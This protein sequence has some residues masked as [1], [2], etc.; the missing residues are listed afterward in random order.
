[1]ISVLPQPAPYD[2]LHIYYLKGRVDESA[3]TA[4][5]GFI[6]NWEEEGE[7]F[8]FFHQAADEWIDRLLAAQDQ[9]ELM[10]RFQ[11][12]YEEWQ[13]GEIQPYAVGGLQII[14]AW[15][16]VMGPATGRYLRLDPGV[17][18]GTGTHPTTRHC[19]EALHRV[20]EAHA[21]T[22][23]TDV[24]TGTGLLA[25]A[26]VALGARQVVAVDLN[27]LAVQTARRNV[28]CNEMADRILV[29][30]GNA[31]NFMDL[32]CDL[33]VSNIHYAVMRQLVE[34]P[35]FQQPKRF[36]LSGLLR[37]QAKEIAS[38]LKKQ[39]AVIVDQWEQDAA[40]FTI[41]G[42]TGNIA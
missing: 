33:M 22:R 40:W 37:S 12:T 30:R 42:H 4:P 27:H 29:V 20:F 39:S 32:S 17:V 36:I 13:G 41:Y 19:L 18:F 28:L 9:L 3:L 35:G 8:L 6:G 7:S 25:L 10:D 11:M 38:C 1:M 15:Y 23:V 34:S 5:A 14:P 21:I 16:T 31:K 2:L 24:G 26:S